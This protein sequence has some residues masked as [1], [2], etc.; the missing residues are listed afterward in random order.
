MECGCRA[1]T[2]LA[3]NEQIIYLIMKERGVGYCIRAIK[4]YLGKNERVVAAALGTLTAM[5]TRVENA[6]FIVK[7]QGI[8]AALAALK[9]YPTSVD[10]AKAAV[11]MLHG[12]CKYETVLDSVVKSGA[13]GMYDMC[14]IINNN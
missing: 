8:K 13:I 9:Q 12:L 10:I 5:I 4:K 1:L 6:Q 3:K 7:S 11:Q 2:R 14:V